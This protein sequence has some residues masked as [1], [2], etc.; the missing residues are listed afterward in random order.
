MRKPANASPGLKFIRI[1]PFFHT[2][3]FY[4]FVFWCVSFEH[5]AFRG[6]RQ[7]YVF[8]CRRSARK[9]SE[10]RGRGYSYL[11]E[12]ETKPPPTTTGSPDLPY[13]EPL[14]VKNPSLPKRIL[15]WRKYLILIL[16]PILLMPLP[17][18]VQGKVR[19][20]IRRATLI[21]FES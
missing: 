14:R 8:I 1:I 12:T 5:V 11:E 9:E 16:T 4:C 20:V 15:R 21:K 18:A 2:N 19:A 17:I 6:S 7:C 13:L 10:N 3:D